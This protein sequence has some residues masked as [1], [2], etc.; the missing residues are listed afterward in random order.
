MQYVANTTH[1]NVLIVYRSKYDFIP[2]RNVHGLILE[3]ACAF[4]GG[5]KSHSPAAA[6]AILWGFLVMCLCRCEDG[7][8][9]MGPVCAYLIHYLKTSDRYI[10]SY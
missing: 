9:Y 4:L 6:T 8:R 5:S 7:R 10:H 1:A 2:V 3:L